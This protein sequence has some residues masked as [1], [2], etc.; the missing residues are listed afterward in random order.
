M[1]HCPT[2]GR[3]WRFPAHGSEDSIHLDIN[4]KRGVWVTGRVVD[5]ATGKPAPGRVEYFVFVDNPYLKQAPGFRWSMTHGQ[6]TARDGSFHLV[7]FPGPGLLA[8]RANQDRYVFGV[9]ADSVKPPHKAE[10]GMFHCHP[11]YAGPEQLPCHGRDR[12]R[13]GDASL[14]RK[15]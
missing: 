4:L 5:K 10:N 11:Y 7:A 1:R 8:T 3:G 14:C 15:T 9:G 6:F 2:C 13:R 12:P